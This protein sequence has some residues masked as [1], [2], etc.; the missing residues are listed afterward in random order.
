MDLLLEIIEEED[1]SQFTVLFTYL[2]MNLKDCP[3]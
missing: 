3:C 1:K 2:D